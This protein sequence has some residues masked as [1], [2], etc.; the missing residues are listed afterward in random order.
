MDAL[1]ELTIIGAGRLGSA[2]VRTW[3]REARRA[4]IWSRAGRRDLGLTKDAVDGVV[5]LGEIRDIFAG[6]Y[7]FSAISGAALR[8]IVASNPSVGEFTGTFFC[9]APEVSSDQLSELLPKAECLRVSPFLL[10]EAI[11]ILM[12]LEP[13]AK[14]GQEALSVLGYLG[15]VEAVGNPKLFE[16][17]TLLGSP[18]PV[19]LAHSLKGFLANLFDTESQLLSRRILFRGIKSLLGDEATNHEGLVITPGGV[20][21]QGLKKASE[22]ERACC[23]VLEELR[24]AV[25]ERSLSARRGGAR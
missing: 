1:D 18:L 20:T 22:V 9:G 2:I 14:R 6:R 7:V 8:E 5:W 11:F 19:V 10:G 13:S 21:E 25:E 24:R 17:L 16:T 4:R 12:L 15:E 23:T 3:A